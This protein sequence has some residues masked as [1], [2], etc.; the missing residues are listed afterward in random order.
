MNRIRFMRKPYALCVGLFCC[1]YYSKFQLSFRSSDK[2]LPTRNQ[3]F[4]LIYKKTSI[5]V[6]LDRCLTYQK[7]VVVSDSTMFCICR[8]FSSRI[9]K[10]LITTIW[11]TFQWPVISRLPIA[12]HSKSSLKST[13][14]PRNS[15]LFRGLAA[16][17]PMQLQFYSCQMYQA[18]VCVSLGDW[19]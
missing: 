17:T 4:I 16:S 11:R 2:Y 7:M 19:P 12:P 3:S 15:H 8:T 9:L 5:H 18:R 13:T 10:T 6:F 1:H 14:S